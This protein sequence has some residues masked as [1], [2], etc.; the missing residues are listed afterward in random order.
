[1]S[2]I[3]CAVSQCA[4]EY[5]QV[6]FNLDENPLMLRLLLL[7]FGNRGCEVGNMY[8][9]ECTVP[10]RLS[11]VQSQPLRLLLPCKPL[12]CSIRDI[13]GEKFHVTVLSL[14]KGSIHGFCVA[15]G[16]LQSP[17]LLHL[18]CATRLSAPLQE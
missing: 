3:I 7:S 16:F 1:M 6:Y 13:T 10:L 5:L 11:R 8:L 4:L 18:N 17:K 9:N 2:H 12:L 14:Q 15:E